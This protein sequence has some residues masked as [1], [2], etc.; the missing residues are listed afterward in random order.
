MHAV[1]NDEE[2]VKTCQE[3]NKL[4]HTHYHISDCRMTTFSGRICTR[5][6]TLPNICPDFI[7]IDGPGQFTVLG[8]S[9]GIST[10]HPDRLPMAADVLAIE[11]FLLPGTLIVVDGR[12]ANARFLKS[13]FQ[14]SWLYWHDVEADQ[15]FFEL[16]EKPLGRFNKQRIDFCLGEAY[17]S[18]LSEHG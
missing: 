1:E 2:W 12:T 15:H 16:M 8:D 6:D 17:Y 13:N 4:E 18:R 5:F 10:N 14:R 3:R 9:F 7:Y 11:H